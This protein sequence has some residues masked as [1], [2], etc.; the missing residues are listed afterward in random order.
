MCRDIPIIP[1]H[2]GGGCGRRVEKKYRYEH[3]D[4][5]GN[6]ET[7]VNVTTNEK[8]EAACAC[9]CDEFTSQRFIS[10]PISHKA[11]DRCHKGIE[12]QKCL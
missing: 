12:L 2:V 7:Q 4:W 1:M 11:C 8:L 10:I 6:I 5:V 3:R 9:V